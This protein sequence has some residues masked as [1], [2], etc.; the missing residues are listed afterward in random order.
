MNAISLCGLI[1]EAAVSV[2]GLL[3]SPAGGRDIGRGF[4]KM[5]GLRHGPKGRR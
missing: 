4:L 5:V 1:A 3:A 2:L